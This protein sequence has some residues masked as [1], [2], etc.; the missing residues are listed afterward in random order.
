M[1]EGTLRGAFLMRKGNL[2]KGSPYS[3]HKMMIQ[4]VNELTVG[5]PIRKRIFGDFLQ[6]FA[7]ALIL[8][9]FDYRAQAVLHII[10]CGMEVRGYLHIERLVNR[11]E[12]VFILSAEIQGI[13]KIVVTKVSRIDAETQEK[14]LNF[15]SH[16]DSPFFFIINENI[17]NG[18]I[19]NFK[20]LGE[21][22]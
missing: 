18:K 5:G 20:I 6:E 1:Q 12:V 21:T 10:P 13:S 3:L 19:W 15:F 9:A 14:V 16:K 7:V 17:L 11:C 2:A 22:I 8:A 4:Y